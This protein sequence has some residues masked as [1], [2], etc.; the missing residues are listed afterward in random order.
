M[1]SISISRTRDPKTGA[2]WEGTGVTP[3]VRTPVRSALT[4]AHQLA[5]GALAE[6]AV[7]PTRRRQYE[8]T[9]EYVAAQAKPQAVAP[10]LLANYQG[11]YGERNIVTAENGKLFLR[12]DSTRAGTELVA[13]NDSTC[14]WQFSRNRFER[15]PKTTYRMVVCPE[16]A[17]PLV[18]AR[19]GP[20]P[21]IP[22]EDVVE[23]SK[24]T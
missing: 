22:S 14:G 20:A 9:K 21:M 1:T 16:C 15:D 12:A 19:T 8:L 7:D 2:E 5:L 13:L 23:G 18:L 17:T 24:P 3:N 4:A 11:R 10:G 6:K